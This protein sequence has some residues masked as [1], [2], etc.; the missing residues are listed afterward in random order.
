[1]DKKIEFYF[2]NDVE[3]RDWLSENYIKTN[4]N[5][6]K[7]IAEKI[8]QKV[9]GDCLEI[10]AKNGLERKDFTRGTLP[11]FFT[12]ISNK[13]FDFNFTTR[14]AT[15]EKA[16]ENHQYY[17]KSTK[18]ATAQTIESIVPEIVSFYQQAKEIYGQFVLIKLALKSIIPLA[19]LNNINQE[20]E[21]IKEDNSIRLNAEFNQ[22]ISDHIKDQPAPFIYERIGQ[23]FQHYF[24]DEMQDTS[25]LQWQNLI[26]LIDNALAQENSNLLLVGD[27]KQAIYRWRGGKAEQFI[28]L[29]ADIENPFFIE[30][31]I[32]TLET[33]FR[34]YS[35]VINFNNSFFQHA[36]NF[37]QNESYKN[38]FFDHFV[39]NKN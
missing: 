17:N 9:G 28:N 37:L 2:K 10:L 13:G 33:N 5:N 23:R 22:L 8:F 7:L 26:P 39:N 35:E 36:A 29:G 19:V 27:G 4:Y 18:E 38:L 21:T 20:L 14:C 31:N 11:D 15:I 16:I 25:E 6:K 24:I 12:D 30:K 3:W 1:M 34:S 32:K